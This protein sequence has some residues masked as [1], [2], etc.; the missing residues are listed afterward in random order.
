MLC[1]HNG[2]LLIKRWSIIMY[3][4]CMDF[5]CLTAKEKGMEKRVEQRSRKGLGCPQELEGIVSVT[6]RF[7]D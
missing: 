5:T 2:D 4:V 3:K 1:V 6:P 7:H